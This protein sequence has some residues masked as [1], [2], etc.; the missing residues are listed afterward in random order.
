MQEGNRSQDQIIH[1]IGQNGK[2][3]MLIISALIAVYVS[4]VYTWQILVMTFYSPPM[5]FMCEPTVDSVE[6]DLYEGCSGIEQR[7]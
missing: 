2:W 5:D 1:F 4:V 7:N 3:Q 6:S